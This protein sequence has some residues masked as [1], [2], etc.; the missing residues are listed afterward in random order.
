MKNWNAPEIQELNLS[1]TELGNRRS[2]YCDAAV[3]SVE[4]HKNFY[5]Y[6][7]EGDPNEDEWNI[8]PQ[9]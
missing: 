2:G 4:L 9:H 3:W 6:S 8:H 5:S 1:N 7:G